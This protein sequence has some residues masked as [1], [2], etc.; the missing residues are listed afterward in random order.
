VTLALDMTPQHA[1]RT[2]VGATLVGALVG[3]IL[4]FNL[5][6]AA[7]AIIGDNLA[8]GTSLSIDPANRPLVVAAVVVGAIGAVVGLILGA[9]RGRSFSM[10]IVGLLGGAV[11]GAALGAFTA[12][13]FSAEV[14]VAIGIAIALAVW[15]VLVARPLID[16]SYDW[17]ALKGRYWPGLTVETAR[18]TYEQ[19]RQRI[20][21]MPRPPA[22][23]GRPG[24]PGGEGDR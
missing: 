5:F 12:I 17:E 9:V 18:E 1:M 8:S 15:P 24:R 3:V 22:M 14:A 13:T 4:F 20:P 19:L 11:A 23:P 2:L 16:G 6:H 21:E 10:S 7:W